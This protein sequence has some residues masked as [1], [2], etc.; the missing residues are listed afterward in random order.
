MGET[1]L[2]KFPGSLPKQN[3]FL[4]RISKLEFPVEDRQ[5]EGPMG[6]KPQPFITTRGEVNYNLTWEEN[7][8]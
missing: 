4:Q 8:V 6:R 5:M 3:L 1:G 2:N 7:V